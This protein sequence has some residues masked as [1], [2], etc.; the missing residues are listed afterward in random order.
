MRIVVLLSVVLSPVLA[1]AQSIELFAT[2]GAVQ[3]WDDEG[4][5]GAGLPIGGGIGFKSPHGW[6]IELLAET[7]K[8]RRN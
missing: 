7:Q 5:L 4:N 1:S 8:A 3:L 6:G 2:T